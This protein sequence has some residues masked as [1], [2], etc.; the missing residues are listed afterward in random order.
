MFESINDL[1]GIRERLIQESIQN[2]KEYQDLI[3]QNKMADVD[4]DNFDFTSSDIFD[5]QRAD[6]SARQKEQN[7]ERLAI[8]NRTIRE[9]VTKKMNSLDPLIKEYNEKVRSFAMDGNLL[10]R[11]KEM[12]QLK[13]QINNQYQNSFQTDNN[14]IANDSIPRNINNNESVTDYL[15]YFV[16]FMKNKNIKFKEKYDAI[17]K[18]A[19]EVQK[20][21]VDV[22]HGRAIIENEQRDIF[23]AIDKRQRARDDYLALLS[24]QMNVISEQIKVI[25]SQLNSLSSDSEDERTYKQAQYDKLYENYRLL[26]NEDGRVLAITDD[27]IRNVDFDMNL[28]KKDMP[29][30]EILNCLSNHEGFDAKE[31]REKKQK[32][33][34]IRCEDLA[35]YTN[36]LINEMQKIG[37]E[38]IKEDVA[39]SQLTSDSEDDISQKNAKID[40]LKA[41]YQLIVKELSRINNFTN[42]QIENLDFDLNIPDKSMTIDEIKEHLKHKEQSLD[43]KGHKSYH[44]AVVNDDAYSDD[45]VY[46]TPDS[47]IAHDNSFVEETPKVTDTA[48][49]LP[50]DI[51][52]NPEYIDVPFTEIAENKTEEE[53]EHDS[54]QEMMHTFEE[55]FKKR[56]NYTWYQKASNK[57]RDFVNK[58]YRRIIIAAAGALGIA[59]VATGALGAKKNNN[60]PAPEAKAITETTAS[61]VV[62]VEQQDL[63]KQVVQELNKDPKLNN[64]Q[65]SM[66]NNKVATPSEVAPE[67]VIPESNDVVETSDYELGQAFTLNPNSKIFKDEYTNQDGRGYHPYYGYDVERTIDALGV[68]MPNGTMIK[69]NNNEQLAML[70]SQGGQVRS[71]YSNYSDGEG[72][73]NIEDITM[74]GLTR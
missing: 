12:N 72:Y 52:K 65:V 20:K 5:N 68:M 22:V 11:I 49:Q 31:M 74:K 50:L 9:D 33:I 35:Y 69:A 63:D 34:N 36:S 24:S 57:V 6:D 43:N 21:E 62:N 18:N 29:F 53:K 32:A 19:E 7:K 38:K 26:H 30:Q 28:P 13:N 17:H 58:N 47:K 59:M 61:P 46:D 67:V 66:D 73:F 37:N 56:K 4:N 45:I 27:D 23:Q 2:N 44:T 3:A 60:A 71:V 41:M 39:V 15:K 25:R 1:N 70:E 51:S 54:Y 55:Q 14:L 48:T 64:V 8:I 40:E 16:N 10:T 42:E